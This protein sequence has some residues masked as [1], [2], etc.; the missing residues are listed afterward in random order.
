VPPGLPR[1]EFLTRISA[2]I[3]DAT[4]RLVEAGQREQEQ[5]FGRVPNSASAK[6]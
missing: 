5:L 6:A 2:V 1:D 3:E 4:R